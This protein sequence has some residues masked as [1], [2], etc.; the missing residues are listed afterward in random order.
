MLMPRKKTKSKFSIFL[1]LKNIKFRMGFL[2]FLFLFVFLISFS[3]GVFQ[4]NPLDVAQILLRKIWQTKPFSE[5][6]VHVVMNVRLPRIVAA[7]LVGASLAVS[8]SVY[9]GLFNNP[10]VSPDLL[11]STAGA[12]FGAALGIFLRVGTGRISFIAFVFGLASVFIAVIVAERY[13]KDKTLGLVLSGIMVGSLF[14]AALSFIKLVSDPTDQLPAITYWLMGS[15]ASV[16]IQDLQLLVPMTLGSIAPLFLYRWQL[17][18]M[19]LEETEARSLGVN[20]RWVRIVVI[21]CTTLATSAC[22]AVSGMIGWVGLV[23]PHLCRRFVGYD[24]KYLLPASFFVGATFLIVV[25]NLSRTLATIEVPIG[26]LTAFVGAPFFLY[27][28]LKG[29]KTS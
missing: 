10:M 6:S 23:I 11:G 13:R 24:F 2:F 3:V 16:R 4:I 7:T 22:V 29:G 5:E 18:V 21:V 20:I 9:Q 26:I 15:L 19:T 14:R 8:G 27:L 25:D 1:L 12:S 17:N 28:I